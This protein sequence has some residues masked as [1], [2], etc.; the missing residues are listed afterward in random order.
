MYQEMEDPDSHG[1]HLVISVPIIA[2]LVGTVALM[3]ES[4]WGLAVS[5]GWIFGYCVYEALHWLFHA[6]DPEK[7]LGK[8][9]FIK[10]LWEAHTVHH[11]FRANKNYGFI[12]MFW[13][14]CFGTFITLEQARVKK[15]GGFHNGHGEAAN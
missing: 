10:E 5:A 8:L 15:G 9:F 7:G 6:G 4:G 1:I 3:T 12:A 14:K 11:L 13:D 2:M